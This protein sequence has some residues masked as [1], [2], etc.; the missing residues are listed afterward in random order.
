MNDGISSLE[1]RGVTIEENEKGFFLH[2]RTYADKIHE[3]RPVDCGRHRPTDTL[4]K[5]D[6]T[7]L[8]AFCGEVYWLGV[9]TTPF[10]LAWVA[11]LQSKIP[12]GT[13]SLFTAAN[14][15]VKLI[16]QNQHMG[17]Q[18]HRHDLIDLAVVTWCDAAW[19]SRPDG[20]SQGGYLTALA[21]TKAMDGEKA[22]LTALDWG[23]KK[24]RR[25][26]R[27]LAA[28]VQEA[29]DAEGAQCMVHMVLSE[30]LFNRSP[31]R[32]KMALLHEIPAVLATDCKAFYDGAVRSALEERKTLA[33]WVHSHA[34]IADGLT[35]GNWQAFGVLKLF[36][37]KQEWRLIYDEH[38][39]SARKR[40]ALGM[41]FFDTTTPEDAKTAKEVLEQRRLARQ[42]AK[43]PDQ[44]S[45]HD[46]STM[47]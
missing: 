42:Q 18:I 14:S 7:T 41:G 45:S 6:Q 39:M 3:V 5:K 16:K 19:A 26:A 33:W 29:G 46:A 1:Q 17:L 22:Q 8:M 2:Q 31:F 28:E 47:E 40:A 38:Y 24:L 20:N 9:N 30:I 44:P 34:Q 10:L 25:V 23:S 15:I 27:S 11:E 21:A 37:E 13:R 36:L 12:N 35:K 43:I 32:K 4:R